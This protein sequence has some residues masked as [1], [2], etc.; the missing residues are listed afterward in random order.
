MGDCSRLTVGNGLRSS[1]D[2]LRQ[3][4]YE[5]VFNSTGMFQ[6][7]QKSHCWKSVQCDGPHLCELVTS[8]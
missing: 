6:T 8:H 1:C 2:L 4:P 3:L 7:C 5:L